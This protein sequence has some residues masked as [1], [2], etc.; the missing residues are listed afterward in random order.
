MEVWEAHGCTG[1]SGVWITARHARARQRSRR[2]LTSSLSS[3]NLRMNLKT[4]NLLGATSVHYPWSDA[5]IRLTPESGVIRNV[6]INSAARLCL[7]VGTTMDP[8]IKTESVCAD[9]T[10]PRR[11]N[12]RLS[13]FRTKVLEEEH[14]VCVW[15]RQETSKGFAVCW[16]NCL[17]VRTA[18]HCD[19]SMTLL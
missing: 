9:W 5:A 1:Q 18:K 17:H 10:L 2:R 19:C 13:D 16:Q 7:V 14:S 8:V 6:E 4:V 15:D 3:N 11:D 12:C